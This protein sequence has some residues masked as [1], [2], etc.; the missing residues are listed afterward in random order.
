MR[1]PL[2]GAGVRGGSLCRKRRLRSV[3][4]REPNNCPAYLHGSVL[5]RT[6][7]T[8]P[9]CRGAFHAQHTFGRSLQTARCDGA[10]ARVARAVRALVDLLQGAGDLCRRGLEGAADAGFGDPRNRL[11]GAVANALAEAKQ[12]TALWRLGELAHTRVE[13]ALALAQQL[14]DLGQVKV[15]GD[16]SKA[17]SRRLG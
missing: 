12:R 16:G 14:C 9:S 8:A 10:A 15:V 17:T 6:D 11:A 13:F 7:L 5:C 2:A 1:P 3:C 4:T